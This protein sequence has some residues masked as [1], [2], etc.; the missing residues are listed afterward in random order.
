MYI[1]GVTKYTEFI[2]HEQCGSYQLSVHVVLLKYSVHVRKFSSCTLF[3]VVVIHPFVLLVT[4]V[5][6]FV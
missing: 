4:F 3:F 6:F 5:F 2:V 1:V